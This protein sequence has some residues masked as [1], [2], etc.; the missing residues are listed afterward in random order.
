MNKTN[1]RSNNNKRMKNSKDSKLSFKTLFKLIK[2]IH[3]KFSLNKEV[4]VQQL[5]RNALYFDFLKF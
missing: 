1:K 2:I 4:F 5:V 3:N